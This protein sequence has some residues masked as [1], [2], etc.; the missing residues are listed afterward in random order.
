MVKPARPR[1]RWAWTSLIVPVLLFTAATAYAECWGDEA[2]V[3]GYANASLLL[4]GQEVTDHL[5]EA[6]IRINVQ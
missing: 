6:G 3:R 1:W 2:T 5:A 4:S